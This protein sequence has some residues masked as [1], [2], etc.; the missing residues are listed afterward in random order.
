M[1]LQPLCLKKKRRD[2]SQRRGRK[3]GVRVIRAGPECVS[4]WEMKDDAVSKGLVRGFGDETL[5]LWECLLPS[6][7]QNVPDKHVFSQETKWSKMK[8]AASQAMQYNYHCH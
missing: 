3:N 6:L 7:V 1:L 8:L 5:R 2:V 4:H